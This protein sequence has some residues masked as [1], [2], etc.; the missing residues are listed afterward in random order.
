MPNKVTKGSF[1]RNNG[2]GR[3]YQVEGAG[4]NLSRNDE[5]TVLFRQVLNA[6]DVDAIADGEVN[7]GKAYVR[8]K[9][10]FVNMYTE[11][12]FTPPAVRSHWNPVAE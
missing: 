10:D 3:I 6:D 2:D 11:V 4:K 9:A 12:E 7:V 1:Y 8:T 5:A